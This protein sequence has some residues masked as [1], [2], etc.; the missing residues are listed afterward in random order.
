MLSNGMMPCQRRYV[1][2][3]PASTGYTTWYF[4]DSHTSTLSRV[5]VLIPCTPFSYELFRT[6]AKTC[7]GWILELKMAMVQHPI[8]CPQKLGHLSRFGQKVLDS[9]V[10]TTQAESIL[11]M[12]YS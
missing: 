4:S 8:P 11:V 9:A 7:G 5:S 10:V 6:I 2:R 3:S 1:P 12:D